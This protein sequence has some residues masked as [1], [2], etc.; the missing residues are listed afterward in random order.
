MGRAPDRA[1]SRKH[2]ITSRMDDTEVADLDAG[3]RHRGGMDRSTY[4]RWLIQDDKKR[5]A[6]EQGALR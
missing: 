3:G 2:S 1:V 4:I 5:I 6:R